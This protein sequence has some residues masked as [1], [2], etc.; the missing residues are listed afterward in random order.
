MTLTIELDETTAR[1]LESLRKKLGV[2]SLDR[3]IKILLDEAERKLDEFKGK[4]EAFLRSLRFAGE[5]GEQDSERVD[6]LLYSEGA[7]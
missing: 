5:A 6:E 7:S 4:P 2:R 3:L 1:R